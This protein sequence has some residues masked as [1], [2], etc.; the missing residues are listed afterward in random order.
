MGRKSNLHNALIKEIN[1]LG[2]TVESYR[3]FKRKAEE[4]R[5][6]AIRQI[7]MYDSY[8]EFNEQI[9]ARLNRLLKGKKEQQ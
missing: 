6:V 5:N 4:A 1:E 8:I 2:H 9:I 7:G 3:T